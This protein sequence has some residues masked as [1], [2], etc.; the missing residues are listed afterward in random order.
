MSCEYCYQDR[1]CQC[2]D[3]ETTEA[4]EKA[5]RERD[6]ILRREAYE[7]GADTARAIATRV[8]ADKLGAEKLLQML[9]DGDPAAWDYL[10]PIPNLSGEW[11]DDPTPLSLA[12]EITGDDNPTIDEIDSIAE[13]WEDG[14]GD[15]YEDAIVEE[16]ERIAGKDGA[17]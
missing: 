16:L 8:E 1:P 11:A 3:T 5:Q 12:Q 17:T 13:A 4:D 15:M 2:Q 9:E 7:L 14:V 10:P 6:R